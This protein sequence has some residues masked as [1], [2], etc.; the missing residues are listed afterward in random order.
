[1]KVQHRL[2]SAVPG[3]A[4]GTE[5]DREEIRVNLGQ[6]IA[7]ALQLFPALVGLGREK[8]KAE[9]AFE[10]FLGFHAAT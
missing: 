7:H 1:V 9:A 6:R 3:G 4:A 10:L 2:H 8:L 5:G